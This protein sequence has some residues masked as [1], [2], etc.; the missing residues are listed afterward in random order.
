MLQ[1][2]NESASNLMFLIYS[3]EAV[4]TP[5][6]LNLLMQIHGILI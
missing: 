1:I 5:I 4:F 2:R 3:L 6:V